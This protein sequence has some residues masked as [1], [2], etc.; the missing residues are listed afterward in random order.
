MI[1]TAQ[2]KKHIKKCNKKGI[3]YNFLGFVENNDLSN[4]VEALFT[5]QNHFGIT[6]GY[7]WVNGNDELQKIISELTIK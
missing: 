2:L 4:E 5:F 6:V 3:R 1:T 7:D